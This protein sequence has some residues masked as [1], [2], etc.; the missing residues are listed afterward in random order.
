MKNNTFKTIFLLLLLN[1]SGLQGFS[2]ENIPVISRAFR[3]N[4]DDTNFS[5]LKYKLPEFT[6]RGILFNSNLK[7]N[8]IIE[9]DAYTGVSLAS[10]KP[11]SSDTVVINSYKR[12]L[13][14]EKAKFLMD[15]EIR[16]SN[17]QFYVSIDA[18]DFNNQVISYRSLLRPVDDIQ[19]IIDEA[20]ANLNF[21]MKAALLKNETA[22]KKIAVRDFQFGQQAYAPGNSIYAPDFPSRYIAYNLKNSMFYSV[23]SYGGDNKMNAFDYAHSSNHDITISGKVKFEK[24]NYCVIQPIIYFS[25]GDSIALSDVK[26]LVKN[27]DQLLIKVLKDI[28]SFLDATINEKGA[29]QVK[30]PDANFSEADYSTAFWKAIEDNNLALAGY[31]SDRL[32][33]KFELQKQK[34][35]LMQG[36]VHYKLGETSP[37]FDSITRYLR[38]DSLNQEANYYA[39]LTSLQRG[40]YRDALKYFNRVSTDPV[41][42]TCRDIFYQKGFCHYNLNSTQAALTEFN[43]QIAFDDKIKSDAYAYAAF[44]YKK[45]DKWQEAENNLLRLYNLDTSNANSKGYLSDH[46]TDYAKIQFGAYNY[47]TAYA[48]YQRSYSLEKTYQS[49]IGEA[50]SMIMSGS[51]FSELM[52]LIQM[53]VKDKIFIESSAYSSLAYFCR[54]QVDANGKFIPAYLKIAAGLLKTLEKSGR[55]NSETLYQ[56]LG[57]TYFRLFMLD[58]AEF[59]YTKVKDL[60]ADNPVHYFNLAELQVMQL[61]ADKA[62]QTLNDVY[63]V[64]KGSKTFDGD[65]YMSLYHVYMIE[66]KILKSQDFATNKKDFL[67]LAEKFKSENGDEILFSSW[68]FRTYYNWLVNNKELSSAIQKNMIENLCIALKYS[69]D[70]TLSCSP[71]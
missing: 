15:G 5:A 69:N 59:Y 28:Q 9:E 1:V 18:T 22:I 48:Y 16:I 27:R 2:Q 36:I 52:A 34:A 4:A 43:K 12:I 57:S 33:E 26:D 58:S 46:Y 61:K 68:S 67:V 29:G 60:A 39:G 30:L 44:C 53:G 45:Q 70:K 21:Q 23:L 62:I 65:Y 14:Y 38:Y 32:S 11:G 13:D 54:T 3:V 17:N 56:T 66:S 37:A 20:S 49:L 8:K 41:A 51:G 47:S 35:G 64:M 25:S 6:C 42:K 7:L 55:Y 24:N 40:R 31:Y 50:Q 71:M 63:K 10:M 19:K